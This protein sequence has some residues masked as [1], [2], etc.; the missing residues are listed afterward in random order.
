LRHAGFWIRFAATIIDFVILA[1]P[2]AVFVSFLSVAMGPWM[3]F[4]KLHPGETREEI[5]AQFGPTFLPISLGF[6]AFI[7][8]AYF[9]GSE[10]SSL[11][12]TLGKRV[13]G[14]YV[15]NV[16]G[17]PIGFW[18]ASRRFFSGRLLMQVPYVGIYYFVVDCI[19]AGLTP[20][21]RAIHDMLA[22]CLV[23]RDSR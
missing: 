4:L 12:G 18:Q 9:A 8:W 22:G 6:F 1:L 17:E 7:S 11:R 2:L 16:N 3:A 21:N 5:L 10:S 23:L 13:L 15:A 19:C 14:L 20:R